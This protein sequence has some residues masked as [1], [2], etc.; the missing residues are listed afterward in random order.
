MTHR[1]IPCALVLTAV[2]LSGTAQAQVDDPHPASPEQGA[3]PPP[4]QGPSSASRN[5]DETMSEKAPRPY[6]GQDPAP[7]PDRAPPLV[8]QPRP[9]EPRSRGPDAPR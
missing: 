6:P 4:T 2:L 7:G 8:K 3:S 5:A 1:S 9:A